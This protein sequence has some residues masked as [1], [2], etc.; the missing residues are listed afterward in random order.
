MTKLGKASCLVS[1]RLAFF[2]GSCFED[3]V[4]AHGEGCLLQRLLQGLLQGLL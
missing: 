1:M 3:N 4:L 2:H